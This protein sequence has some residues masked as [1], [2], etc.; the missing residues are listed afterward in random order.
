MDAGYH[1]FHKK[2][3]RAKGSTGATDFW[4][5]EAFKNMLAV[6]PGIVGI[7]TGTNGNVQVEIEVYES[8]P[9]I[10]S[11]SWDHIA[12]G[13]DLS[14]GNLLI[15]GCPVGGYERL[16]RRR[17]ALRLGVVLVQRQRG[18][19]LQVFEVF[20]EKNSR[21]HHRHHLVLQHSGSFTEEGG[22]EISL[23]GYRDAGW[24]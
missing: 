19:G 22:Q 23:H 21:H 20:L 11:S 1:H 24:C 13:I 16:E 17:P 7:A 18:S 8:E 15:C 5:P 9:D 10:E 6:N 3:E 4:T 2:D 12:A 14:S